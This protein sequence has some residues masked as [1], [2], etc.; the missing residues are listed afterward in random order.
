MS[1]PAVHPDFQRLAAVREEV[2]RLDKSGTDL[3]RE[4][5]KHIN[6]ELVLRAATRRALDV[7]SDEDAPPQNALSALAGA[8]LEAFMVAAIYYKATT[9]NNMPDEWRHAFI[10]GVGP[11]GDSLMAQAFGPAISH[12]RLTDAEKL[13]RDWSALGQQEVLAQW[14]R[15]IDLPTAQRVAT[16]RATFMLDTRASKTSPH[17]QF[18]KL[19]VNAYVD[20]FQRGILFEELGGHR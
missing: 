15:A 1:N 8:W 7:T 20:G 19:L 9:G 17:G 6:P 3:E 16:D 18:R 14:A 4:I 5:A 10:H 12:M 11:A 13:L 2:D